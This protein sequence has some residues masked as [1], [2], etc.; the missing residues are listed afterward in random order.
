MNDVCGLPRDSAAGRAIQELL[1]LRPAA[2][3]VAAV[4]FLG[5]EDGV[6][7]NA[8]ARYFM[9]RGAEDVGFLITAVTA[10]GLEPSHRLRIL[11][12]ISMLGRQLDAN[13][14]LTLHAAAH[15]WLEPEVHAYVL[16]VLTRLGRSVWEGVPTVLP[17]VG[18]LQ[19]RKRVGDTSG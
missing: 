18:L 11:W 3:R 17:P 12:V 10:G 2:G 5:T 9:A 15:D 14:W 6:K 1:N 8:A 7:W 13:Q 16:G 19:D 4:A